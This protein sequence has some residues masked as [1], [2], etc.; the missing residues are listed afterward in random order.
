MPI[1]LLSLKGLCSSYWLEDHSV[2][3]PLVKSIK[4]YLFVCN[5]LYSPYL[6][7]AKAWK[8]TFAPWL[9]KKKKLTLNFSICQRHKN[10]V[11]S[12]LVKG[13]FSANLYEEKVS[14]SNTRVKL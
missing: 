10:R 12:F 2:W 1:L 5:I 6:F 11:T 7:V 14:S 8:F 9:K 4:T 3:Q 13:S